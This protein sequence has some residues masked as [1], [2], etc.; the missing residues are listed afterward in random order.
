MVWNF[1]ENSPIYIQL[2]EQIKKKIMSGQMKPG[3]KVLSVRDFAKEAGVNPNTMQK[4]FSELEREQLLYSQR[5]VGRF[6]TQDVGLIE[7]KRKE[8][9]FSVIQKFLSSCKDLG[10]DEAQLRQL[11]QEYL[12]EER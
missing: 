2:M 10:Y 11:V 5:T 3:D 7:E 6:V 9:V 4:A 8:M 12:K 1:D